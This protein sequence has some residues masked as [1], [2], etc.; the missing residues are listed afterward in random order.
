[1]SSGPSCHVVGNKIQGTS[2]TTHGDG[3]GSVMNPGVVFVV[4]LSSGS[5]S[6]MKSAML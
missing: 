1:M 2:V 4:V 5:S 6:Q 3:S